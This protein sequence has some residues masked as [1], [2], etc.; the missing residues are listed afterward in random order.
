[1]DGPLV[2]NVPP[3]A[4]DAFDARAMTALAG[5]RLQLRGWVVDRRGQ[6]GAGQARW[7]L[8]V[9]HPAMLGLSR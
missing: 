6:A 2:V 3:Q 9:T 1:M 8:R 7:M 5:K 4:L